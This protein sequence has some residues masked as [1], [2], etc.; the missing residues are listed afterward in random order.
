MNNKITKWVFWVLFLTSITI[1]VV[2]W[3]L[4]VGS[5][6]I[7][8]GKVFTVLFRGTA[9]PEYDIIFNIRLPRIILGFAI[10]GALSLAGILLQG[11]FRNPLVEPYTLGISGGAGL[12]V[13]LNILLGFY[14]IGV[15]T[16]PFSGFLGAIVVLAIVYVLSLRRGSSQL[17]GLLLTG[18]MMSFVCSS[19]MM[20]IMAISRTEDLHGII[21]WVMGSLEES[22]WLMIKITLIVSVFFLVIAHF[23]CLDLNALSLGEEEA[24]H[25]GIHVERTKRLLFIMTSLLTGFCVS[26]AG[27]IGFVG[28][29]VPHF[30]RVFIGNDHRVS[31][32]AAFLAGGAFLIFCDTL[33]R[34]MI[35]PLEL[36]VGVITGI[37]GGGLFIYMLAKRGKR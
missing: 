37:I 9:G 8:A 18:V 11:M 15:L 30:I 3:S 2:I 4:T 7:P 36:P 19:V 21:F 13:S 10:G 24:Q 22:N 16:L 26:V 31:L 35:A 14:Q 17:Q 33:A 32:V 5:S 6:G 20:L 1:G 28:L 34:T 27:I 29:V 23:F 12:G 25:L